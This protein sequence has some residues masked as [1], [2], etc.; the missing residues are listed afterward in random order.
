[1]SLIKYT[2]ATGR[3]EARVKNDCGV[4]TMDTA[5]AGLEGFRIRY[6]RRIGQGVIIEDLVW[7]WPLTVLNKNGTASWVIEENTRSLEMDVERTTALGYTMAR[8]RSARDTQYDA[9]HQPW[10]IV[11]ANDYR[12]RNEHGFACCVCKVNKALRQQTGNRMYHSYEPAEVKVLSESICNFCK[13]DLLSML[14]LPTDLDNR[15]LL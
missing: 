8:V 5:F 9:A 3:I 13:E 7:P 2:P 4:A 12:T 11:Q 14:P 15:L 1:M 10:A 6:I